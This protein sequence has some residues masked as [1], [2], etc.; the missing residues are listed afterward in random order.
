MVR[1]SRFLAVVAI[2]LPGAPPAFAQSLAAPDEIVLYVHKDMKNTDFVEG[3]V[4]ELGR[5]LV[6]PVRAV[7]IDLPLNRDMLVT[8][9]QFEPKRL[10]AAFK[11]S[12]DSSDPG[13]IFRFLLVP[14]DLKSAPFH[15]VF[16]ETYRAPYFVGVQSTIRLEPR[17]P[18]MSRKQISDLTS[19][20]LYKLMIKA[21][22]RMAGL[23]GEGCI[24]AFP[25][26]LDELDRKSDAF[27]PDDREAMVAAGILKAKPFGACNVVAMAGR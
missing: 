8:E 24:L 1:L 4:C 7:D 18:T 9:T 25:R 6:A 11:K 19:L 22:A 5:V 12:I 10:A 15:Y 17:D 14:Y 26:S 23:Q 2:L 21:V 3:L 16:A 27:C 13:R 20:R